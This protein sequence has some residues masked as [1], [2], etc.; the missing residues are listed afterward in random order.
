MLLKSKIF[1][2]DNRG[3]MVQKNQ[4]VPLSEAPI[5]RKLKIVKIA[6]EEDFCSRMAEAG[7]FPGAAIKIRW[8]GNYCLAK[9]TKK[10]FVKITSKLARCIIVTC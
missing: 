10:D 7:I 6:G 8:V 5:Q 1:K 2:E 9:T 4:T 3:H